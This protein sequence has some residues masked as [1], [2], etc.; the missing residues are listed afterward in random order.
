MK[1][2]HVVKYFYNNEE[3]KIKNDI[4]NCMNNYKDCNK[5]CNVKFDI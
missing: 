5:L 1:K 4:F 2:K 3:I